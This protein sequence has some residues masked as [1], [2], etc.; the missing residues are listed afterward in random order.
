MGTILIQKI[1]DFIKK[2]KTKLDQI[3][4]DMKLSLKDLGDDLT[5]RRM[6]SRVKAFIGSCCI[7]IVFVFSMCLL[8][9]KGKHSDIQNTAVNE[10]TVEEAYDTSDFIPP[11]DENYDKDAVK[12][13]AEKFKDTIAAESEDAGE[14]YIN[15]TL[16]I[17]DSNTVRMMNY[18]Y[19]SLE[20]TLAVTGMGIQSVPTLKC[21]E[22]EGYSSPVTMIEA[23][24][25][26]QPRRIIIT[27][28]TNNAGGMD[29]DTF[30]KKYKEVLSEIHEAYSY[31][32]ILINSVP[33]F[34]KVNHYP[35]LSMTM[36]DK[37]NV[38]LAEMAEELGYKFLD[39][40]S[41]L[42]DPETGFAKDDC[43][44]NDGIHITKVGF[45]GMFTYFR[46][47]SYITEDNRPKPLKAV[48]KQKGTVYV[49]SGDGKISHDPKAFGDMSDKDTNVTLP[50]V[51]PDVNS[52]SST[53]VTTPEPEPVVQHTHTWDSGSV[54]KQPTEDEKG[55]RVYR[56]SG[57]GETRTED[58]PKKEKKHEE[59]APVVQQKPV[60]PVTPPAQPEAP[61][62]EVPEP[63][64][65]PEVGNS[66][67]QGN[68]NV[69][70]PQEPAPEPTPEKE[71]EP[72]PEPEPE[73]TPEPESESASEE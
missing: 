63:E 53:Q 8:V 33:P 71:P 31:A 40:A 35:S 59:P 38:A 24:K 61:K 47:H 37:Y 21:I 34:H 64:P 17:G 14:E 57:C 28:G 4:D 10:N 52:S 56:C 26:M 73:S 70:Q 72:E 6:T 65:E 23:V 48:P 36:V 55:K 11:T 41:V 68:S 27:F 69:D 1:K 49:I 18:G 30:I 32:D 46:T 15:E 50:S 3:N 44:V 51:L 29:V 54:E 9:T 16:F 45:E 7:F 62:P 19:T 60:E 67:N 2:V 13:D 20:N 43:T 39:S 42:K 22:F 66:D 58:I 25:I 5:N 12:I